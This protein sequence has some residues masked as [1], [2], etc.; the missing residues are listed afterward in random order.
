MEAT[1]LAIAVIGLCADILARL[2]SVRNAPG[3]AQ[4]LLVRVERAQDSLSRVTTILA[5]ESS[6]T[7]E[8]FGRESLQSLQ[9]SL[10]R[11]SETVEKLHQDLRGKRS[12]WLRSRLPFALDANKAQAYDR[13]LD[14]LVAD[15]TVF[16]STANLE[17]VSLLA[18][19]LRN[20]QIP[21]RNKQK[22][23]F[24]V[25]FHTANVPFIHYFE[26]REAFLSRLASGLLPELSHGH[27]K[28][29]IISGLGGIGKT[30]LAIQ[31]ARLNEDRFS[32]I[33]FVDA[34]NYESLSHGLLRI[35]QFLWG[36]D[37]SR[38]TRK[39]ADGVQ[40]LDSLMIHEV[41]D[42]FCLEGNT[43]W[44]LI[45]DNA[46]KQPSDPEGVD[47]TRFFPPC[48]AGSILI[49]TRL[50]PLH[51]AGLSKPQ[52]Q[53]QPMT[54]DE[55][56]G[57]LN[58]Y[59]TMGVDSHTVGIPSESEAQ[60]TTLLERLE[61][62]PLALAQAGSFL[63]MTRM[64]PAEYLT[65]YDGSRRQLLE[66][67]RSLF[68]M[69][70]GN[71][72]GNIRTTWSLSLRDLGQRASP[73]NKYDNALKLLR[74]ITFFDPMDIDFTILCR[75]LI[76]H[77]IPDWFE[78]VFESSLSFVTTA[79]LLVERS[80]LNRT[81]NYATYSMHRVVY[82]WL[83]AEENGVDEQLLS[84]AIS[85]IAFSAPGPRSKAWSRS[86]K[87]LITHVAAMEK[88]LSRCQFASGVPLVEPEALT[89]SHFERALRLVRDPDW[90]KKMTDARSPLST[91]VYLLSIDEKAQTGLQIVEVALASL[92][93]ED[94]RQAQAS[95]A[96]M[97]SKALLLREQENF[98]ASRACLLKAMGLARSQLLQY[99]LQLALAV[100]LAEED[101]I[102]D[103]ER[104]LEA[105]ILDARRV[106][107]AFDHPWVIF[108][109]VQLEWFLSKS[110]SPH[111]IGK[112]VRLLEPYRAYAE[113]TAS[114]SAASRLILSGL[115]A[116]YTE[117][118]AM[119]KALPVL[120]A[121]L[122]AELAS[123]A[124]D[125]GQLSNLYYDLFRA[126][127]KLDKISQAVDFCEKWFEARATQY[128]ARSKK[129]AQALNDLCWTRLQAHDGPSAI[130]AGIRAAEMLGPDDGREYWDLTWRLRDAYTSVKKWEEATIWGRRAEEAS[131][132][133]FGTE[134]AECKDEKRSLEK[135]LQLWR[136]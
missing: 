48:N 55:S 123:G 118:D 116:A 70:E 39:T 69:D 51:I 83:C 86:E 29:E 11:L 88:S 128:G 20:L 54:H 27:R 96:L 117:M 112:R 105:C 49:T 1:G 24:N 100:V 115:G 74:L 97:E 21:P 12:R 19:D 66:S 14:R 67:H 5:R 3:A 129:A 125:V 111:A 52:I 75:G 131:A 65:V 42:W 106:G 32:A 124:A 50:N 78:A 58:Y 41:L 38:Q 36:G 89:P 136:D 91:I 127:L 10:Q 33:F 79:E 135:V 57:L 22:N 31:F 45:F 93:C 80:L 76:G 114:H 35:H 87:R 13:A 56:R 40:I 46:D 64:S 133:V 62:L 37:G 101:K 130:E 110:T 7:S 23:G 68:G 34:N 6:S 134:S 85:A 59:M 4:G 73:G 60:Q 28:L 109:I 81:S 90:Y 98:A 63:R 71:L 113:E 95:A 53:L 92:N 104:I 9:A 121:G 25:K 16:T 72:R 132:A 15:I 107:L 102:P 103:A 77:H 99:D 108:A 82:D 2:E 44:L 61:G 30:Q 119:D 122:V 84:V 17:Q 26:G 8:A 43:R 47:I 18:R 126:Y 94:N 120:E